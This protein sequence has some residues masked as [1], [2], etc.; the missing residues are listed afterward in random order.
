VN[1]LAILGGTP[2]RREPW[3][4]WPQHGTA[5]HEAIRRVTASNNYHPQFGGEVAAFERTFAEYHGMKHAVGVSSGT[6]ALQLAYA[7]LEI[8]CGDEIVCPAYTYIATASAAVDQNAVPVFADSEPRSQGIDPADARRRIGP[9]TKAIVVVHANGYPCDLDGVLGLACERGLRVVEDCSHAHGALYRERKVGTLGDIGVFSLQHKKN[10]N[11]GMGGVAITNDDE[12][13]RRMRDWR[14]FTGERIGHNWLM[15][16]FHA[17]IAAAQIPA[18]DEM[19]GR[20]RE[21]ARTVTDGIRGVDG[22][23]PLP[24]LPETEPAFYNLILQYDEAKMGAPRRTF[25]AALKA[26][27]IPIHMFYVPLQR[28]PIIAQRDVYGRGCPFACPLREDGPAD[29]RATRT[30]VADAICDR[31]NLEIKVQPTSGEREMNQVAEAIR[32]IA[33]TRETLKEVERLLEKK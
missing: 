24:G 17:A 1:T 5:V 3:P 27:G 8:G 25:V 7:A 28:W 21:N 11:A 12:L 30:P 2:V 14:T 4:A 22:I 32:K 29:Y 13:A 20:R 19:N 26:E 9:R 31:V 18:L 6:T 16:E 23:V 15:S 33:D 10:L